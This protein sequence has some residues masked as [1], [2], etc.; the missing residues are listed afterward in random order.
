M[1]RGLCLFLLAVASAGVNADS[2]APF[3]WQVQGAHATHY[4]L[5]SVHL[6]PD[7]GNDLPAGLDEAYDAVDSLVFETNVGA[8]KQSSVQMAMM[9]AAKSEHGLKA[10]VGDPLYQSVTRK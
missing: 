4:L 2:D 5:G 6:L 10:E 9:A 1:L 3:L 8:L 7:S